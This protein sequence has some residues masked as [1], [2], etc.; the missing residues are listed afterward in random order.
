M[1]PAQATD[2][3]REALFMVLFVAGPILAFGILVGLT[4]ALFQAVTSLQEQTL[5][6]VPKIFAMAL[7]A[8]VLIPYLSVRL[9]EYC[10]RMF[11]VA[12]F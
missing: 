4:I 9:L 10:T 5:Q 12:P 2:L 3:A 6:F 11:G 1:S 8:V 7:A